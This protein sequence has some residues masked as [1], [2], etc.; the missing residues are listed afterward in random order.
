MGALL[1][2]TKRA[3]LPT[4]VGEPVLITVILPSSTFGGVR[5]IGNG[6]DVRSSPRVRPSVSDGSPS[7][8]S[9]VAGY[10]WVKDDV[11]SHV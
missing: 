5:R 9:S 7:S 6:R 10:E 2:L 8:T 4:T 11:L 3:R 1:A